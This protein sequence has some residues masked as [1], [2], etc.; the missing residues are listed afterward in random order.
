[1]RGV[2]A[3]ERTAVAE[4]IGHEAAADPVL[5]ADDLVCEAI[6]DTEDLCAAPN[7]DR[8]CRTRCSSGAR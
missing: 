8:R 3:D 2:A 1:M 6:V 7:P 4:A 5:L